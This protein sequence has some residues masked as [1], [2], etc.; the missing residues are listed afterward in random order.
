MLEKIEHTCQCIL[1]LLSSRNTNKCKKQC[2][3][4]NKSNVN[5]IIK[6]IWYIW[7][8]CCSL[9]LQIEIIK[10]PFNNLLDYNIPKRK[11]WILDMYCWTIKGMLWTFIE[12]IL[13]V[14]CIPYTVG[15]QYKSEW[16]HFS[17]F[18]IKFIGSN[19]Q[20]DIMICSP[21]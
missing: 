10:K 17:C 13:H 11:S 14:L 21:I 1:S 20:L 5:L 3:P 18:E 8:I 6:M 12:C 4:T 2:K 16:D 19:L 7:Y 9:M 15:Y